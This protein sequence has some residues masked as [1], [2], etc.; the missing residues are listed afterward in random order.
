VSWVPREG[1]SVRE[2][3]FE[4]VPANGTLKV[5]LKGRAADT[6]PNPGNPAFVGLVGVYVDD[7]LVGGVQVICKKNRLKIDLGSPGKPHSGGVEALLPQGGFREGDAFDLLLEL[8]DLGN[9]SLLTTQGGAATAKMPRRLSGG[10]V[11]VR[12]GQGGVADGAYFPP[13]GWT[14]DEVRI[15][16]EVM[17]LGDQG[18]P[19]GGNSGGGGGGQ[20]PTGDIAS[21]L[22]EIRRHLDAI[23]AQAR[24]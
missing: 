11:L 3:D 6:W 12:I 21:H 5:R 16:N 15:D 17:D 4:P 24:G 8:Q 23:E 7:R 1:D 22:A 20:Q 2:W 18:V 9:G 13:I 19:A 10:P 14:F